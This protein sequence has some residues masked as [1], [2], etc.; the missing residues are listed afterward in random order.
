MHKLT[1]VI[2]EKNT[3]SKVFVFVLA[4][5]APVQTFASFQPAPNKIVSCETIQWI[6]LI[7]VSDQCEMSDIHRLRSKD[8]KGHHGKFLQMCGLRW[9]ELTS[10][11]LLLKVPCPSNFA[12]ICSDMLCSYGTAGLSKKIVS[13]QL[14]EELLSEQENLVRQRGKELSKHFQLVQPVDH[15]YDK[16][17]WSD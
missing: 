4:D 13:Y 17:I 5:F 3:L 10:T 9:L 8:V 2:Q 7:Q 15:L 14:S 12:F 6:C 11:W 16:L 1:W